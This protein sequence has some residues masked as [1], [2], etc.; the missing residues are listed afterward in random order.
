MSLKGRAE[1][2]QRRQLRYG[3]V[4]GLGEDGVEQRRGVSLAEDE[5]V[6]LGP[7]GV[8]R[9][10]PHQSAEVEGDGDLDRRQRA[11]GVAGAGGR[12][13]GDDVLADGLRSRLQVGER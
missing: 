7:F 9:V 12:G 10:V 3:E 5:A 1:F 11:G 4:A 2:T 8:L 13:A 6:A